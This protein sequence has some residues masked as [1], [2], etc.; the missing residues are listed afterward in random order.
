[1]ALAW[2]SIGNI[3]ASGSGEFQT[4]PEVMRQKASVVNYKIQQMKSS[5]SSLE[6]TVNQTKLYWAGEASDAYR[7]A[8]IEKKEDIE[9]IILRL[10]EHVTELKEMAAVYSNVE[11]EV[12]ELAMDLPGD[13]IV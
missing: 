13:V 1:M 4:D 2:N 6:Y 10:S 8:F 3:F 7:Q 9:T 12:N 11:Q 5:F